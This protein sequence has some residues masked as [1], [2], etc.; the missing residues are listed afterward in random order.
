M[1]LRISFLLVVLCFFQAFVQGQMTSISGV[2]ND[3]AKV[4]AVNNTGC[5][6]TI[7][8]DNA[9]SFSAGQKI[10]LIQMKGA[11]IETGN[12]ANFGN[13]TNYN[14]AGDYEI[15]QIDMV[16]G[17]VLTLATG[18]RNNYDPAGFVLSLIHI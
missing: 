8:V 17:N 16:M 3:Y 1:N 7:T 15:V 18:L 11:T 13:I 14:G 12:N 6:A 5:P 10:L 4:T 2:I 9:S